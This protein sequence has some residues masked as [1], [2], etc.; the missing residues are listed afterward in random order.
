MIKTNNGE[1]MENDLKIQKYLADCGLMSRRAA[2]KEIEQGFVRINGE[3]AKIG[4]RVNPM[5]DRVEYKGA[6]VVKKRGVHHTY[7][8]L[9]KPCGYVTTMSD[10]KGR[11]TVAD[12]ITDVGVR[13]YPVG[14]LD[15]DSE[16]LL[17]FTDDGELANALTHPRHHI[18]KYYDV[19]VEGAVNRPTLAKLSSEM[20]IDGY[21]IL[22]VECHVLKKSEEKTVIRMV[23]F[24]GRNRQIRKMC[25]HCELSVKK[26]R[27]VAMGD[28]ELDVAKGKWRYLDK[29]EVDYLKE[30]CGLTESKAL[31]A[32]G[33]KKGAPKE[34]PR[35][36]GTAPKGAPRR[37]TP[38]KQ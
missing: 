27:R 34:T 29:V 24:E 18:A 35:G 7:L 23:L 15:M 38:K 33:A 5:K 6:V 37:N 16:G 36:R 21:T 25:E 28:L 8:M 14:R 32:A 19:T 2:E 11:K 13:V 3:P 4:Q 17:L 1:K 30:V 20:E 12:L 10:D 9:N 26:L 22:P 31:K